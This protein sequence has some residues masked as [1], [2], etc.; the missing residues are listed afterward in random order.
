MRISFTEDGFD[1]LVV[2]TP[3]NDLSG[4]QVLVL[5]EWDDPEDD[6]ESKADVLLTRRDVRRLHTALGKWLERPR[7]ATR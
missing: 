7:K 4:L 6:E 2:K 5:D 1:T 3:E